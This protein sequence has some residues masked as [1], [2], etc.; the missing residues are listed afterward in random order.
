M[1]FQQLARA[2]AELRYRRRKRELVVWTLLSG[3][4]V[5]VLATATAA[6]IGSLAGAVCF[7]LPRAALSG[8]LAG[9]IDAARRA[10]GGGRP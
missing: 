4:L 8:A 10:A 1:T 9:C 7:D 6:F 3:L 2:E 5:V